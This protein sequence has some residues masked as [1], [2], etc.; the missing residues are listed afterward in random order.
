VWNGLCLHTTYTAV[1]QL[2]FLPEDKECD[3]FC[4]QTLKG[5]PGRQIEATSKWLLQINGMRI[6]TLDDV[7]TAAAAISDR[8][9]VRLC[10]QDVFSGTKQVRRVVSAAGSR[11]GT[12]SDAM[13]R[14][15]GVL[16]GRCTR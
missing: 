13:E 15:G 14:G 10:M 11:V 4:S 16:W 5:S 1:R 7:L 8:E 12:G 6:R 9:Y 2:G 3:V